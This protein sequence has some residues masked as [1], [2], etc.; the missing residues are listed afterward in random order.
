MFKKQLLI[1][2]VPYLTQSQQL[3]ACFFNNSKLHNSCCFRLNIKRCSHQ[4]RFL[5]GQTNWLDIF[6]LCL[7]FNLHSFCHQRRSTISCCPHVINSFILWNVINFVLCYNHIC[8]LCHR[9]Q[10]RMML[11]KGFKRLCPGVGLWGGCSSENENQTP[12]GNQCGVA[13]A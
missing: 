9:R 4:S 3:F 2:T 10:I 12:K 13:Q 11:M 6:L 7:V 8:S 5:A 1:C